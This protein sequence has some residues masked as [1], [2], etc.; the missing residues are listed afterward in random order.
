MDSKTD[1]LV[2]KLRLRH[3]ELLVALSETATMR[4]ASARLHLSQPAISK[5]LGEIE[6]CFGARLFERSH[7]GI[8]A[9]ALG[10]GAVFHARAVLNQLERATEDVEAMQ[11]GA[12]AMLRIGA[13][14]VTAT[15]P[16]AVAAL[17]RQMPGVS[18]QL[19]EGR[20]QELIQRLL[21]GELDG[22]FGAITPELLAGDTARLLEPVVMLKDELCVLT[23]NANKL[24]R[25]GR[26]RWADLQAA[27]W[28]VPPK[29]TLVRQAFMTAF[30][31]DGVTPPVP[32][33]EAISS[34]TIGTLLRHDPS[35]V[36][37]VRLEHAS[38]EIARG[39][40]RRLN[41]TP[42]MPLPSFGLF[43]RR[44]GLQRSAAMLAFVDA[45]RQ[46]SVRRTASDER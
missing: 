3:L 2:R 20:V 39:G 41:V 30:L 35:L 37:A 40:V 8:H 22:V 43:F 7:Q 28:M 29:E 17:R 36:C 44:D 11:S 42:K 23:A 9:N 32:V 45:V 13:P 16:A 10:A 19:R 5:M 31:D 33:I 6:S 15:V 25:R 38:D 34:V 4:G 18:V 12:L 1:H 26:L 14:S 27:A 21:E 46:A 24:H